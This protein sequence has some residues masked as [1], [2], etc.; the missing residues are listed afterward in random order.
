MSFNFQTTNNEELK[1]F[2][3]KLIFNIYSAIKFIEKKLTSLHKIL[4]YE[5]N[6]HV[7]VFSITVKVKTNHCIFTYYK[8]ILQAVICCQTA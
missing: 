6:K 3:F 1:D 2:L 5:M 7:K 8:Q 4:T